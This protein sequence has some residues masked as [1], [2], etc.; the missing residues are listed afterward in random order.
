MESGELKVC[1][2]G[3][4][5]LPQIFINEPYSFRVLVSPDNG[6]HILSLENTF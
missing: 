3:Y 2:R 1:S 6:E 4:S 5:F